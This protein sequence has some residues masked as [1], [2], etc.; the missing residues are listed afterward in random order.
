MI[1]AMLNDDMPQ[2]DMSLW[3]PPSEGNNLVIQA[4]IGCSFNRCTFYSMYRTK[5]FQARPQGQVFADF[6]TAAR[7]WPEA[8]R[9]ILGLG[10]RAHWRDHIEGT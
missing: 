8:H 2:Y 9:V 6:K 3:R 10:G 4:T 1:A 7:A 5:M